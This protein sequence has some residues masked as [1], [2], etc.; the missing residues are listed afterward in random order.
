MNSTRR[1]TT[2]RGDRLAAAVIIW[3]GCCLSLS[4]EIPKRF[5]ALLEN[6]EYVQG[7][8]LRN[9]YS[10]NAMPQL[11]GR[12]LL[13]GGNPM[14]WLIDT[15]VPVPS[16]PNSFVELANGDRLPG[17]V[18][19]HHGE[20]IEHLVVVPEHFQVAS[21][22]MLQRSSSA[23]F[24]TDIRVLREF[25]RK[26]VWQRQPHLVDRYLPG[27]LIYRNG[28]QLS[29]RGIRYAGSSV[30]ILTDEG[31]Q[32]VSFGEIAELHLPATNP[33]ELYAK[34]L[35]I[36]FAGDP[37][38]D[39]S[40]G[41][42]VQWDT[43]D[44]VIATTALGRMDADSRGN[45]N[46]SDRWLH[47]IQPAWSLDTLWLASQ[48]SWQR[49]SWRIDQFP[50]T[51]L[52]PEEDRS[53]A[54]FSHQGFAA[55]V[56]RNVLGREARD[57]QRPIGWNYGVMAPSRLKF[58][59]GPF[60]TGL[61]TRVALDHAAGG[62]GC[63]RALVRLS[64]QTSPIYRSEPLV[65][66]ANKVLQLG[67]LSWDRKKVS[68]DTSLILEVDPTHDDRPEGADPYDIRDLTNWIE[69][70]LLLDR[71]SLEKRVREL[72][73]ELMLAWR[74]WQLDTP[75][76]QKPNDQTVVQYFNTPR[77][78]D[79]ES[80]SW[81][82]AV[83]ATEKPIRLTKTWRVTP[84]T[85]TVEISTAKFGDFGKEPKIEI[86]VDGFPL[87]A[88]VVETN[89]RHDRG[90]SPLMVSLHHY[91]GQ[92]VEVSILQHPS[93]PKAPIDWRAIRISEG[94][95]NLITVLEDPSDED[96]ERIVSESELEGDQV[97]RIDEHRLVNRPAIQVEP[98]TWVRLA[99]FDPPLE[100]R[101]RPHPDQLKVLRFAFKKLGSG[102]NAMVAIRIVHLDDQER[103]A[104]MTIGPGKPPV[105][106]AKRLD[107]GRLKEEWRVVTR[108]LAQ[109]FKDIDVVGIE[110]W[111]SGEGAQWDHFYLGRGYS[112]LERINAPSPDRTN[113]D[114]WQERAQNLQPQLTKSL[115][116]VKAGN[117]ADIPAILVD[118]GRRVLAL[119]AVEPIKRGEKIEVTG[120][121]QE[122]VQAEVRGIDTTTGLALAQ[123]D[124]TDEA[125]ETLAKWESLELTGR[126]E[127][128]RQQVVLLVQGDP[129]AP[130]VNQPEPQQG[131]EKRPLEMPSTWDTVRLEVGPPTRKLSSKPGFPVRTGA[132]AIDQHH[133]VAGIVVELV[134][135]DYPV[136]QSA[137]NLRK[138]WD[139]LLRGEDHNEP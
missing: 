70:R 121:N 139:K 84:E 30:Q 33:W 136:L 120:H 118:R 16:I 82:T 28:R 111:S 1:W 60:T 22:A 101:E 5:V 109:E 127:F 32:S 13:S 91:L 94:P 67:K 74:G 66:S 100:I 108:D 114:N 52:I 124:E 59:V 130:V 76:D 93:N 6:G 55:R 53:G 123:I 29:Y 25:V 115:L 99:S 4:A 27:T 92:E 80:G 78:V 17:D 71:E 68:A 8:V 81:R 38:G 11:A 83:V 129:D 90:G 45:N 102:G 72:T 47:G 69:P 44:G 21:S 138:H 2:W 35:A 23:E 106:G 97:A 3:L 79:Y 98:E 116:R 128:E 103:P 134:G 42:L 117:T 131:D 61:E 89:N 75:E 51:R 113:W 62:G 105:E 110:V 132:I 20:R 39:A 95:R 58:P 26:I 49:R 19:A 18:L 48:Q 137:H 24:Q 36:L 77:R 10:D 40:R 85:Q 125:K 88:E 14:L 34:E 126:S 119:A 133:Q 7:D 12:D 104:V 41:R 56:N 135:N 112:D 63:V 86:H 31:R 9:W 107:Q 87:L 65:G 64:S 54:Y 15:T 50:L 73:P 37:F 122:T 46:E 43:R 57:H 96:I